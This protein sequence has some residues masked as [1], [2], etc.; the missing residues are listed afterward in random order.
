MEFGSEEHTMSDLIVIVYPSEEKAEEVRRKLLEMQK[1]YLIELEDAVIATRTPEGHVR[2]NQLVSSTAI[3]ALSGSLWGLLVGALLLMPVVGPAAGAVAG[4]A[5]GAAS[6]AVGGALT[7]LGIDDDFMKQLGEQLQPGNAALFLLV[8]K[9]TTDKVLAA[10]KGTGGTLL[11]TSLD[12]SKEQALREAL[13]AA[14]EEERR[15]A[16]A[17]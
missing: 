9:M 5:I 12:E 16:T 17:A 8:R 4:A 11:K 1:E 13:Q 15:A 14:A 10:L 7:D 3:G 6:G 2:L